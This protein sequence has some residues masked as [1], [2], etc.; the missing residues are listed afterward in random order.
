MLAKVAKIAAIDFDEEPSECPTETDPT[1]LGRLL[2]WV[3][4]LDSWARA[5]EAH[6]QRVAESGGHVDL[7]KLVRKGANRKWRNTLVDED[8]EKGEELTDGAIVAIMKREFNVATAA[9]M[10]APKLLTGPQAEKLVDKKSRA[11]FSAMLLHKP[12][13][14]LTLVPDSDKRE[15]VTVDLASDFEGVED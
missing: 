6:A 8:G 13:G 2:R 15:E 4:F 12:E 5:V 3:P 10:T 9:M 14:K 7:H 1:L 11:E